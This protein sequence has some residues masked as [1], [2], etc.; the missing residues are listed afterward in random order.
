MN[1]HYLQSQ[2]KST[3][4]AYLFWFFLGAHYAYLGKWG[5]Q[6]LYWFTGGGLLIW[7]LVDLFHIPSKV[8]AH[9]LRISQQ[10]EALDKKEQEEAHQR[11][12]QMAAALRGPASK[13]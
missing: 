3:G 5:L 11:N 2:Y 8:E 9:N 4:N 6:I 12:L 7:M 10:L 1:K 13:E